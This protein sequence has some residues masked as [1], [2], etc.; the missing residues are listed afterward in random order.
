[1]KILRT[2]KQTMRQVVTSQ[3]H[4]FHRQRRKALAVLVVK[5]MAVAAI[6]AVISLQLTAIFQEGNIGPTP[7]GK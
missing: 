1:M 4:A 2:T 3:L 6:V 7:Q 5:M